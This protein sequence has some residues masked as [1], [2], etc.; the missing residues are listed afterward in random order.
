MQTF[1]PYPDFAL[2]AKVLDNKRL[3]KQ[4]LEAKQILEINLI[5]V[6]PEKY[7]IDWGNYSI[8]ELSNENVELSGWN[9][10]TKEMGWSNLPSFL[11][12]HPNFKLN[13]ENHPAV[14]MWRGYEFA[15]AEYGWK[16]CDEWR[17]RGFRD[18]QLNFFYDL[19]M[20][21]G[22][23]GKTY[24]LPPWFGDF[25]LHLSHQSNLLRK[26]WNYYIGYFGENIQDS[27]LPYY[28]PVKKENLND[29]K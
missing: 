28:W 16:I 2:S 23:S 10:Q 27:T 13:W 5:K 20:Q 4:R 18:N 7:G 3:G 19:F 15:L 6:C 17:T 12:S 1:L 22:A 11:E 8:F 21:F 29:N 9:S 14:L 25:K 24:E 26:D